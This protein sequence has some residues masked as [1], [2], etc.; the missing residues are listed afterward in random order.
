LGRVKT[1]ENASCLKSKN[2]QSQFKIALVLFVL[3]KK[4]MDKKNRG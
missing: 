4:I 2:K 1:Q 3:E